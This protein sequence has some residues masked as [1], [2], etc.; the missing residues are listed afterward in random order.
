[1]GPMTTVGQKAMYNSNTSPCYVTYLVR[2][3][4]LLGSVASKR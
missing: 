3:V 2:L 4:L 1:M